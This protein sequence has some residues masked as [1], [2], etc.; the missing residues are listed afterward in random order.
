MTFRLTLYLGHYGT[1]LSLEKRT[2]P[3]AFYHC[4]GPMTQGIPLRS[5][6]DYSLY[7]L[8]FTFCSIPHSSHVLFQVLWVLS[9]HKWNFTIINISVVSSKI[10]L[11]VVQTPSS[12]PNPYA[13]FSTT[14]IC[15][16]GAITFKVLRN[17]TTYFF[18]NERK[19]GVLQKHKIVL[20]QSGWNESKVF[21]K[22][23]TR[24]S[25]VKWSL[26]KCKITKFSL[27]L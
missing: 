26:L 6:S 27:N 10:T 22:K 15:D 1:C 13:S 12:C 5:C 24:H 23:I 9:S 14:T 18:L 2:F 16:E 4:L 17:K 20:E 3:S 21:M 7:I 8:E 11:W 19:M 25:S